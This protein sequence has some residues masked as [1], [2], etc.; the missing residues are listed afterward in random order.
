MSDAGWAAIGVV[1]TQ[2]VT[3]I[4]CILTR[5]KVGRVEHLVNG[6]SERL[7]GKLQ[8]QEI[9]IG[10]LLHSKPVTSLR[11]QVTN[12]LRREDSR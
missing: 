12:P 6:H 11:Q 9:L 3:L 10:Q 8:S 7:E 4:V 1:V 2:V 5:R